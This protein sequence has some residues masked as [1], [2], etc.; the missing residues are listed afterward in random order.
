MLNVSKSTRSDPDNLMVKS[1]EFSLDEPSI[2]AEENVPFVIPCKK[3][4]LKVEVK[5][6]SPEEVTE[7]SYNETVGFQVVSSAT[8]KFKQISCIFKLHQKS[9]VQKFWLWVQSREF[10]INDNIAKVSC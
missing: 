10:F 1:N 3:A 6:M 4:S 2:F 9:Q 8:R 5:L 7:K